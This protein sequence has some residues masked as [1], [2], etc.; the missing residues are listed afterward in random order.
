[1]DSKII[2]GNVQFGIVAFVVQVAFLVIFGTKL[3]YG[4]NTTSRTNLEI[5]DTQ[6][7]VVNTDVPIYQYL[8]DVQVMMVV[9]FGFLM[10]FL[11]K[12]GYSSIGYNLFLCALVIQ[13]ALIMNGTTEVFNG[14]IYVDNLRIINSL[15]TLTTVL[16]SF[17]AVLGKVS[18][19]QMLIMAVCEIPIVSW[20]EYLGT[21]ILHVIDTGDSIF[22]HCFGAYFGLGVSLA[23]YKRKCHDHPNLGATYI[24]DLFACIG[25]L[26]LWIYWP[27]FNAGTETGRAQSRAL[28]N[29]I[30]ALCGATIGSIIISAFIPELEDGHEKHQRKGR[31]RFHSGRY[32]MVYFQNSTLA[33]GVAIGSAAAMEL[34]P[35]LA[36]LIGFIA[37]VF[38]VL[39]YRF[40]TKYVNKVMH[41]TCG[42]HN[43]HGFPSF[44]A[45]IAS[46][47]A[48]AF[49][50][51]GR[52]GDELYYIFPAMSPKA[53]VTYRLSDL[54]Y[55]TDLDLGRTPLVQG[56][57]Q[58][59]GWCHTFIISFVG[60][61]VTGN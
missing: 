45:A 31:H 48:A 14:I 3:Q 32:N 5:L 2:H 4:P 59:A 54:E 40:F 49:A 56:G 43:L 61:L 29:T 37:G 27:S 20:N 34:D 35:C 23:L 7:K 22:I 41:D 39:G 12:H 21:R 18:L 42:V 38:S 24:S 28:V 44:I 13:W 46:A 30:L 9:G 1:M 16:I 19:L 47:C 11:R 8:K 50:T 58:M 33:G 10:T 36:I 53:G 17:G 60:G 57:F 52:Y 25:T 55:T 51:R 26:F 6:Q 15:F